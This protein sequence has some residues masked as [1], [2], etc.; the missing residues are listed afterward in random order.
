MLILTVPFRDTSSAEATRALM[1]DSIDESCTAQKVRLRASIVFGESVP[2]TAYETRDTDT[3]QIAH[4]VPAGIELHA[5]G[6]SRQG[7]MMH[8]RR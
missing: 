5:E 8:V 3:K 1:R 4:R 7:E 6:R 2:R